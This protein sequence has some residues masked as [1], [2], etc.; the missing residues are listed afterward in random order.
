MAL[1]SVAPA[2]APA[3]ARAR[4]RRPMFASHARACV[5]A[6]RPRAAVA[7]RAQDAD[8]FTAARDDDGKDSV[9]IVDVDDLDAMSWEEIIEQRHKVQTFDF[10]STSGADGASASGIRDDMWGW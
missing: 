8:A 1:A 9:T 6:S 7:R 2:F 10:G 5:V 4:E 3:P